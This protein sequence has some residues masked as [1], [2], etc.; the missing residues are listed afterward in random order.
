M[1]D[2]LEELLEK[3]EIESIE[4]FVPE[5]YTQNLKC[6]RSIERRAIENLFDRYSLEELIQV[7]NYDEIGIVEYVAE[8][9]FY[10]EDNKIIIDE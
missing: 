5:F 9:Q 1:K 3:Y 8:N 6:G 2:R 7:E 10:I 4:D